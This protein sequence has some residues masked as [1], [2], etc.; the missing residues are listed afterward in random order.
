MNVELEPVRARVDALDRMLKSHAGGLELLGVD[1]HGVV[2][3]RLTGM[4]AGCELKP[5]TVVSVI[6]PALQ[7]LPGVSAV[8][9][10]GGRVSEHAMAALH[11]AARTGRAA[12]LEAVEAFERSAGTA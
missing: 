3:I 2:R 4:C 11:G 6:E 8:Q 7:A 1:P 12:I 10:V 9:I 5:V